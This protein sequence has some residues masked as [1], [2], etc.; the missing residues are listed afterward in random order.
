MNRSIKLLEALNDIDEQ[1]LI[2]HIETTKETN[3]QK[4]D[5]ERVIGMSN[6]RLKYVLTPIM[7]FTIVLVGI[8]AVN[9]INIKKDLEIAKGN[10]ITEN[11]DSDIKEDNISFSENNLSVLGDIDGKSV[12]MDVISKFEFLK[13]LDIPKG[14]SLIDQWALYEREN[15]ND[16]EYSK[17]WQYELSYGVIN[18]K[19][20]GNPE[21]IGIIFTK[22]E[23]I[24]QCML[25][26]KNTFPI[27]TINGLEVYLFK[28]ENSSGIQAFFE[29]NGYKFF[30][31]SSRVSESEF[32][33]LI[34]SI[35]K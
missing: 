21:N 27:S 1:F 19:Y 28:S 26:D 12:K 17:L 11:K 29:Y 30:V 35:I 34:K 15:I 23:Q 5:K 16:T 6:L 18:S 10:E 9:N 2:E 8:I 20:E 3:S 25:P 4:L 14:Y 22:E 7:A 24:L 31:E 13:N 33:A 32:I